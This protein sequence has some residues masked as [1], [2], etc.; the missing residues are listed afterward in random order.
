MERT[1]EVPGSAVSV[2]PVCSAGLAWVTELGV[3]LAFAVQEL[4]SELP[5]LLLSYLQSLAGA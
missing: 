3:S 1:L 5:V 4:V 2:S